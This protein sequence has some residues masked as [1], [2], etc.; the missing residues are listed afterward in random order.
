MILAVAFAIAALAHVALQSV[1]L[2]PVLGACRPLALVVVAAARRP[3]PVRVAWIG[4][5]AGLA[6][7]I[8]DD[9][10]IGPG[11]IAVALA[12]V[13]VA[14]V[15]TRFELEGPLFW[16]VGTLTVTAVSEATQLMVLTSLG[17]RPD[18]GVVGGL[19]AVATTTLAAAVIAVGERALR[20]WRSPNRRRRR[21]LLRR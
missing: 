1:H 5:A 3:G 9:R 19:A 14:V 13:V 11:G 20:F 10:V 16:I 21:A 18:H 6:T 8:L 15:T 7:D 12:G 4:L 2:W 17:T